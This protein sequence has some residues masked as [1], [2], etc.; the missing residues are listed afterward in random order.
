MN[1]QTNFVFA[2][3]AALPLVAS[4]AFG[5]AVELNDGALVTSDSYR[6][7]DNDMRCETV[8]WRI[9]GNVE[10]TTAQ[11]RATCSEGVIGLLATTASGAEP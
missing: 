7:E 2:V 5:H 4:G 6:K 3:I 9:P 8:R 11:L 1:M 10:R